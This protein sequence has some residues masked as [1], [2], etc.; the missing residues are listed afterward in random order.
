MAERVPQVLLPKPAGLSGDPVKQKKQKFVVFA[1]RMA[2]KAN[3]LQPD[4]RL[5]LR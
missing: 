3:K 4:L 2:C 1:S 5:P